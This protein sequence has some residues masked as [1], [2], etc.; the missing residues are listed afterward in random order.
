MT[1]TPDQ[2]FLERWARRKQQQSGS[3]AK[4]PG[5]DHRAKVPADAVASPA[6]HSATADVVRDSGSTPEPPLPSIDDLTAETDITG[7]LRKGVPEELKRLALR[8][9]W[10]LDPAIRDFVEIAENQYDWNAVNGVP[11]F[12]ALPPGTDIEALLAQA[13]GAL[14]PPPEDVAAIDAS[15]TLSPVVAAPGEVPAEAGPDPAPVLASDP[16]R[17]SAPHSVASLES[18]AA[19]AALAN[20]AAGPSGAPRSAVQHEFIRGGTNRRRH[21]GAMPV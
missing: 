21:G 9:M 19:A 1:D 17:H 18:D 5:S 16:V 20:D 14:P 11:G 7:F 2:N 10:S 8:K 4:T 3:G 15:D 6:A 12:G 13:T